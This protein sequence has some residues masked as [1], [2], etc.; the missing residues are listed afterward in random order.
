MAKILVVEDNKDM[1][2]LLSNIL[3][4]EGY[5]TLVAG[6]GKKA[7]KE[8]KR[9]S[10]DLVLLDI[11]LPD[12]DGMAVLE[13]IKKL[14]DDLIIIM[15]TAYGDIKGAVQAMKLGAF[16]YI[17][18]PFDNDELLIAI[19]RALQTQYLSRE[20]HSLRRRLGEKNASDLIV[21]LTGEGQRMKQILKQIDIVSPTNMTVVL[22]G[23][24]GT[25]KELVAQLIHNKSQRSDKA[26][27][28]ID[29]GAIPESLVE[30]E[31]FGYEKGAFTG[32]DALKEG[33]FEQ[34]NGGTLFLDEITN[35]PDSAQ[36]KLLRILQEKKFQ[37][38]GGKRD[39]K[40]DVRIIAASNVDLP[41]ALKA[42]AFRSDLFHRLNEFP[43][44]LPA[45]RERKTDIPFLASRFL[46]EA[47]KEFNKDIKGFSPEAMKTLLDYH[48]P[49]NVRELKNTV[50]RAAL[51]TDSDKITG[52]CL[53]LDAITEPHS[54]ADSL[55][56]N[57]DV[58]AELRRGVSL[59]EIAQKKMDNVEKDIIR[60]ALALAG[61]NKSKAAKMLKTDR[62]T[63]Y[64]RLKKY[65]IE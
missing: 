14:N 42:G 7:L 26:F 34:A 51:L 4:S 18:K 44:V 60:Q 20:V 33:K 50:R 54:D 55:S 52:A 57:I 63:L 16:E 2:F 22:Q 11:R 48:W 32:A 15:L 39:I 38:L 53:A 9:W 29:C 25:G 13:E 46:E 64:A 28:A 35:L 23:E 36:A 47:K 5:E 6:D 31:L 58:M 62:M 3:K 49:G 59:H 17:T 40:V 65:G 30:S 56:E 37:H 27:V 45:L 10:P 24:S 1:Q 8:T 61:G 12:M 41:D 21:E 43:V 19:K